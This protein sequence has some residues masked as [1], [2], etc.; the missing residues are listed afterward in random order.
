MKKF[1]VLAVCTLLLAGCGANTDADADRNPPSTINQ[2]V[3]PTNDTA[4]DTTPEATMS[5]EEAVAKHLEDTTGVEGEG[6]EVVDGDKVEVKYVGRLADGEVFDSNVEFVAVSCG[7][8]K[9][10]VDYNVG[11]PFTVG[12]HRVIK[13]F[14]DG[15]LGMK[16]GETVTVEIP[17]VDAY[18]EYDPE[19]TQ[20]IDMEKLPTKDGGYVVGD[21]L[22]TIYGAATVIEVTDKTVT[23]DLNPELAGKDLIFDITLMGIKN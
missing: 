12:E 3:N 9:T 13:G 15:V 7:V 23:L 8:H 1:A 17:A 21:K 6:A 11:L 2:D 19:L 20:E 16:A 10:F 22:G 4:L 5:C 18:G 14:E